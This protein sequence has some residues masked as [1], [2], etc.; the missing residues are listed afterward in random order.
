MSDDQKLVRIE[1]KIDKINEKISSIDSTLASQHESLKHHIKRTDLL[2]KELKPVRK[3]V[4][5]ING[6][7][8]LVGILATIAAI[9]EIVLRL[10]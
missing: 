8:K 1:D 6:A 4:D 7:L 9:I 5:M 10:K 3:Y 2:E